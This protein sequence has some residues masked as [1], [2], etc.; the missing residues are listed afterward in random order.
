MSRFKFRLESILNLRKSERDRAHAEL[1]KA[2]EAVKVVE[3]RLAAVKNEVAQMRA[4]RRKDAAPG[5]VDPDRILQS[6]RYELFMET[7]SLQ[8]IQQIEQLSLAVIERR[9]R[10]MEADRAVRILEK[11]RDKQLAGHEQELLRIEARD[12]DEIASRN[13]GG[14]S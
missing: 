3:E 4:H 11:L 12:F 2:N 10:L 9:N 1:E 8:F 13:T 7:A 5:N 14:M 6:Q